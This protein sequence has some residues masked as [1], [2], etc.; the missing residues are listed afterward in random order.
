MNIHR[1][2][3][4]VSTSVC[5]I[6][7]RIHSPRNISIRRVLWLPATLRVRNLQR[8]RHLARATQ[9]AWIQFTWHLPHHIQHT[10]ISCHCCWQHRP[11]VS[12]DSIFGTLKTYFIHL[13]TNFFTYL[14][15]YLLRQKCNFIVRLSSYLRSRWII[16]HS[17]QKRVFFAS[18]T[19]KSLLTVIQLLR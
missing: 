2:I 15:T 4:T 13:V 6:I 7:R 3:R 16:K 1:N 19:S 18:R 10:C 14:R 9:S 12:T 8:R 5:W 11:N 17:R